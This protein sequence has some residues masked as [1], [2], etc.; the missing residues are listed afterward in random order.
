VVIGTGL[1]KP[2]ISAMVGQLYA[3]GDQRRDAGF[4]IFYMGINLGAALGPLVCGALGESPRFGWHYG[5]A[6]AGVGM[7]AGLI[8]YRMS[9][10][11][12][13]AMGNRPPPER[14]LAPKAK[15]ALLGLPAVGVVAF[16]LAMEFGVVRLNAPGLADKLSTFIAFLGLIYFALLLTTGKLSRDEGKRVAVIFLLFVASAIFWAGFEQAGSSFNLFAERYTTRAYPSISAQEIPAS[17]FQS[18]GPVFIITLAP[19]MA[20]IWVRLARANREPSVPVKFG[21]GL[22]FLGLGFLVMSWA[23]NF[24]ANGAKVGAQWLTMTY[25]IHT[26][27]ELCLSPVGLSSVTKLAPPR[28]VGRMMGTWFLA[29]SLG[30]ILAGQIAGHLGGDAVAEMP[31]R[32]L[33]LAIIPAILGLLLVLCAKPILRWTR[34]S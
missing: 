7:I 29:T 4:T 13:A 31:G 27:G 9:F 32:Y 2:N 16:A 19:V 30:N 12:L 6:A 8:Q 18:L 15:F 10:P 25:L 21:V 17:W 3:E 11:Q 22:L 26:I 1:L 28:L 14:A 23:S 34:H 24:I 5:F 33:S 20:A